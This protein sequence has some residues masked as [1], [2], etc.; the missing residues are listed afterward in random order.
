[1]VSEHAPPRLRDHGVSLLGDN[2]MTT[3]SDTAPAPE[4]T[5]SSVWA[6]ARRIAVLVAIAVLVVFVIFVV[7]Q[8]AQVVE[9]ADRAHPV[10]GTVVLWTLIVALGAMALAPLIVFLRMPPPLRPPASD[11]GPEFAEH[12]EALRTRLSRN[13]LVAGASLESRDDVEAALAVLSQHAED[14]ARETAGAVFISTAI[15]QSGRLDAFVVLGANFRLI[16]RIAR[17]YWQRPTVRDMAFLYSNVAATAFVAGELDDIDIS[18]Q[19]E[20][21]VASTMGGVAS[22]VPGLGPATNVLTASVL[23][24]AAN[25]YLALRIGMIARRYCG[26]LVIEDRRRLRRSASAQAAGMLGKIVAAGSRR[27]VRA[28]GRAT[29][30]RASGALASLFRFGRRD[31]E[32]ADSPPDG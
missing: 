14:A 17:I 13:Q 19:M 22:A 12:L 21:I 18:E 3:A 23:S 7:N 5:E 16:A 31:E 29:R 20:P 30:E 10:F 11:S 26:A 1:M 24:G 4:T 15:S 6:T 9:L 2:R 27:L 32:D 25:A 8:V 28:M